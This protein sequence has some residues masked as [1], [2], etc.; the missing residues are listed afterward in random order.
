MLQN[1]LEL[2]NPVPS[3]AKSLAV[4]D[5]IEACSALLPT[6]EHEQ[7]QL[8]K[9]TLLYGAGVESVDANDNTI[10]IEQRS[11]HVDII[12]EHDVKQWTSSEEEEEE[13]NNDDNNND[14]VELNFENNSKSNN[15]NNH[16]HD[17]NQWDDDD[18][19]D[20]STPT[21]SNFQI[22]TA[23]LWLPLTCLAMLEHNAKHFELSADL[24]KQAVSLARS[25][26]GAGSRL[27]LEVVC[28][29]CIT[30]L[31]CRQSSEASALLLSSA[32]E[33]CV[34]HGVNMSYFSHAF[35]RY[36]SKITAFQRMLGDREKIVDLLVD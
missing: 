8:P 6:V 25:F 16:V 4:A 1:Q 30:L 36:L 9:E 27:E 14:N 22:R 33:Y 5:F 28:N 35:Q 34:R 32:N 3:P 26:F 31:L 23:V 7:K 29:L 19:D 20:K 10:Q 13:D 18:D 2:R 24:S 15:N 12:D 17:V 11:K 21:I